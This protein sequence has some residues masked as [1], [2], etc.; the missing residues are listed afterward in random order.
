MLNHGMQSRGDIDL[1]SNGPLT[2]GPMRA[3]ALFARALRGS[4]WL[5]AIRRVRCDLYGSLGATGR[6]HGSDLA[7]M[8]GL[9]GREPE[10]IDPECIERRLQQIREQHSLRL[11]GRHEIAFDEREDL[12]F[13][14]RETLGA[15]PSGMRLSALDA[16]GH[17][18]FT[19]TYRAA[20]G[21]L[22]VEC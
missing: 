16:G 3:A 1:G 19:R 22:V 20:G 15:H 12:V 11:A 14:R 6:G 9:E 7:V 4:G 21:D 10:R 17:T 18:L 13:L 2:T 8:L 5:K